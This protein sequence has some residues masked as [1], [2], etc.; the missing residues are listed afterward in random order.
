[1]PATPIRSR[2]LSTP[3]RPSTSTR[4][5]L[6]MGNTGKGLSG[7]VG[8]G[9][10]DWRLE[11]TSGLKIEALAYIRT[12]E[13]GFLT[14]MLDVVPGIGNRYRVATFN[15]ASN[16]NQLSQLRRIN[17][18]DQVVDVVFVGVDGAGAESE[19][20]LTIPA[21]RSVLIDAQDLESGATPSSWP[22]GA[23]ITGALGD[24]TSKWQLVLTGR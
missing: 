3:T 19:L 21:G 6:E 1:M 23:E 24:G 18:G 8:V 22:S 12:P 4:N 9:E 10:G 17:P 5:D 2:S 14:S 13:D 16:A 7:G 11:I 15:P 20:S